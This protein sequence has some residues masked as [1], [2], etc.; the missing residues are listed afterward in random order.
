MAAP[1]RRFRWGYRDR[2]VTLRAT[3]PAA[4]ILITD[5]L[6]GQLGLRIMTTDGGTL[7]H[8]RERSA[9]AFAR[10]ANRNPA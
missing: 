3:K 5:C 9:P 4:E 7:G 2:Y 6:P 8:P 10:Q 1:Y